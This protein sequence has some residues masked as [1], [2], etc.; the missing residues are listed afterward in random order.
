MC[1]CVLYVCA[2]GP[3]G[4]TG[5]IPPLLST[6]LVDIGLSHNYLSGSIPIA[7]QQSGAI[8]L[9]DLSFNRLRGEYKHANATQPQGQGHRVSLEVNRLSGPLGGAT[10]CEGAEYLN[11]LNGESALSALSLSALSAISPSCFRY[12][13]LN[14]L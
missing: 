8:Q 4:L 14:K 11:V 10:V 3:A 12:L 5:T 7:L 9:M 1:A 2:T 13:V 6:S